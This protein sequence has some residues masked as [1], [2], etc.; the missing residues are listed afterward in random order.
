MALSFFDLQST[1]EKVKAENK[2]LLLFF[3]VQSSPEKKK[4]ENK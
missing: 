3:G 4:A 2:L 1:P